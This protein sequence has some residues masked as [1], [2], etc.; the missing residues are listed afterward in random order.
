VDQFNLVVIKEFVEEVTGREA[1]STLE[2]R[3]HHNLGRIGCR[4]VFPDGRMPM[5]NCAVREK[6]IRGK[7]AV[8]ILIHD[9]CLEKVWVR[10]GHG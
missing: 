6:M 8:F 2:G 9:G 5:Q 7:L 10:G 4:N 1:K 3:K